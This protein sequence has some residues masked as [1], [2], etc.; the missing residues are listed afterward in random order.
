MLLVYFFEIKKKNRMNYQLGI[1]K[2]E[3][4]HVKA[5]RIFY[6]KTLQPN[7][8]NVFV[9]SRTPDIHCS[10]DDGLICISVSRFFG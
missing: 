7:E 9:A 10:Y 5:K 2:K 8:L 3:K 4:Y 1:Q 6:Y